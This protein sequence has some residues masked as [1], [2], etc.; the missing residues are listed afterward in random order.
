MAQRY[1]TLENV[2]VRINKKLELYNCIIGMSG[3]LTMKLLI[4]QY[5]QVCLLPLSIIKHEFVYY[6]CIVLHN[7]VYVAATGHPTC[8]QAHTHVSV[9]H[10]IISRISC[11]PIHCCKVLHNWCKI[12]KKCL[13]IIQ[14]SW[15]LK[16]KFLFTEYMSLGVMDE[17]TTTV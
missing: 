8:S 11:E 2:L 1:D 7:V 4:F 12:Q 6:F 10:T 17:A 15:S 14:A 9:K 5:F 13:L 16:L 3:E